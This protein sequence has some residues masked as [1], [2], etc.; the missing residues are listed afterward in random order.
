MSETVSSKRVKKLNKARSRPSS[1]SSSD[2]PRRKSWH[3]SLKKK[4]SKRKDVESSSGDENDDDKDESSDSSSPESATSGYSKSTDSLQ[5]IEEQKA[6]KKSKS[7]SALTGN[8]D[9]SAADLENIASSL[10][11][12]ENSGGG[13]GK[14]SSSRRHKNK[15]RHSARRHSHHSSHRRGKDDDSDDDDDDDDGDI[16]DI[17]TALAEVARIRELLESE[18]RAHH[19]TRARL[20][21]LQARYDALS[22][23]DAEAEAG[24]AYFDEGEGE[25][26]YDEGEAYF[27][28]GEGEA[29]YDEGESYYDEGEGEAYY[30]EEGEGYNGAVAAADGPPPPTKPRMANLAL[31]KVAGVAGRKSPVRSPRMARKAS[32]GPPPVAFGSQ[33]RPLPPS[34]G[35]SMDVLLS[36][37]DRSNR[38]LRSLDEAV[39]VQTEALKLSLQNNFLSSL[40]DD[41]ASCM[42]KLEVLML[43][44]NRFEALPEQVGKLRHLKYLDVA[45]NR[46]RASDS[47]PASLASLH[48]LKTLDLA[49]NHIEALPEH[50]ASLPN[51]EDLLLH[52]NR[53]RQLPPSIANL[54]ATL[55]TLD[56][57]SNRLES[58]VPE[59]AE[60][61]ALVELNLNENALVELPEQL[62]ELANLETLD[63]AH[64]RLE[65]LP[66]S[67]GALGS[68]LQSLDASRN[69][70]GALPESIVR[71]GALK[72]L[73]LAHNRLAELPDAIGELGSLGTLTL[74]HNRFE[75]LPDSLGRL[76]M[77]WRLEIAC[78]RI[79]ALP[80]SIGALKS[81]RFFNASFNRL[82]EL[83][84]SMSAL[85]QLHELQLGYNDLATL[86]PFD[87][88]ALASSLRML[89]V[90]GN[91][92]LGASLGIDH[93]LF[94]LPELA[95]LYASDIGL[96]ALPDG[97][98]DDADDAPTTMLP[99]L[100]RLDV[101]RNEL[102]NV[103][104]LLT[105]LEGLERLCVAHNRIDQP[106]PDFDEQYDV[107]ELDLSF[108]RFDKASLPNYSL[109]RL[110][111][112]GVEIALESNDAL[113]P[114]DAGPYMHRPLYRAES[115]LFAALG[116]AET[117]GR[118]PTQ[119]DAFSIVCPF[120]DDAKCAFI[121]LYDGHSK[122]DAARFA[123]Q[124]HPKVVADLLN[125]SDLGDADDSA[126]SSSSK[127]KGKKK[128]K[129]KSKSKGS[130]KKDDG[131]NDADADPMIAL[132]KRSFPM[133]NDRL[134]EAIKA[135]PMMRHCG[136]TGVLCLFMEKQ[137]WVANVGDS[138]AVLCRDGK[139]MRLSYDHKPLDEEERIRALDGYVVSIR[140]KSTG[141]VVHRVNGQLAVSRSIG[142]LYMHPWVTDKPYIDSVELGDADDFLIIACD[143]VWDEVGDQDAVD[144]VK[145]HL[146]D[147]FYAAAVLRD[148]AYALNSD[149]NISVIIIRF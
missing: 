22:G 129:K 149:D 65:S 21:E 53:L 73:C 76:Q 140:S 40:P 105:R 18:R 139:A 68:S 126:A 71:L 123:A 43:A 42:K 12:G 26:Y 107:Q 79:G 47:L 145:P 75:A 92:R 83:P 125:G 52:G 17:R 23:G 4:K 132:L 96:A 112:R 74:S 48:E 146:D 31:A 5:S 144:L 15:R 6:L 143:G 51:L 84:A 67:I 121:G 32:M 104:H 148:Y 117:I 14:L 70:L 41:F 98:D 24:E 127:K 116:Y 34:R 113:E 88:D 82:A 133:L 97:G 91:R 29:Y 59:I 30:G 28:E 131:D 106:L 37:V 35:G 90:S 36:S 78:N 13:G 39:L 124:H 118:R 147:P 60:L 115:A 100:V 87:F 111:D 8:N 81:L 27:D 120:N 3:R 109:E 135:Q 57:S 114:A 61:R 128:H 142:D 94:S 58:L 20:S 44:Y 10:A 19:E 134:R 16:H 89:F 136:T 2:L 108:N 141:E 86:E 95:Q 93:R 50:A 130:R 72:I 11:L 7:L 69:C 103:P 85:A 55:H 1:T 102:C 99:S 45:G 80:E 56:L 119:E 63:V 54:S 25:A 64:N 110:A 77:L 49:V 101:S 33:S 46:L 62:G 66:H 122:P 9:S 137:L 38:K 138:R